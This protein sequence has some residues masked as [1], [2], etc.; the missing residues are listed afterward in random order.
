MIRCLLV[1]DEGLARRQLRRLIGRFPDVQIVGEAANGV[2]ALEGIAEHRPDAMFLDIEMPGLTAFDL[3]RQLS[4]PPLVVFVTGYDEYA[5]KAFEVNAVDYL[6]KPL[7]ESRLAQAVLRLRDALERPRED[8]EA[9]LKRAVASL[10]AEGPQK[11]AARRGKRI[12]LLSPREVLYASVEDE[13]IFF[14]TKTERFSADRT[15]ADLEEMLKPAGFFRV[16]RSA[17]VNL[18]HAREMVPWLS[19]TWKLKLTNDVEL[20][21]SRDRARELKARLQ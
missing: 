13:L 4:H 12:I 3:M 21:V 18:H 11:L 14:H 20:N 6:L 7:Q 9:A 1:D 8:Y 16:S 17:L 5:I 19:G 10:H 2:E 15:L